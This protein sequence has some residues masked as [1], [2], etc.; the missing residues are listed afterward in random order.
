MEDI[1]SILQGKEDLIAGKGCTDDEIVEAEKALGLH[2]AEDYKAYI[3]RYRIAAFDGHELTGLVTSARTNVV[4]VT[5]EEKKRNKLIPKNMYVV[6]RTNVEEII[7]W[8]TENGAVFYS[9]PDNEPVM[10]NNSLAES[11]KNIEP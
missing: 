9:L 5:Q 11:Y 6:E 1:I 3:K 10:M 2:F 8:Q 7:I 4:S